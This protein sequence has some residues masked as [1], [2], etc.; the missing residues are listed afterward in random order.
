[1]DDGECLEDCDASVR[2][3]AV[4]AL[5]HLHDDDFII[6]KGFGKKAEEGLTRGGAIVGKS[7]DPPTQVKKR[8]KASRGGKDIFFGIGGFVI[9]CA[10]RATASCFSRLL[11]VISGC[12]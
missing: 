3:S 1:M 9:I 5:A 8:K 11:E 10:Q 2:E 6:R 12:R 7:P 4:K